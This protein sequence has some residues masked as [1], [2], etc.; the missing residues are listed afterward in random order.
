[1][2]T[3][4]ELVKNLLDTSKQ[5]P[6]LGMGTMLGEADKVGTAAEARTFNL[7]LK[8]TC[9][10]ADRPDGLMI[11][12]HV[13]RGCCYSI[14]MSHGRQ[15]VVD[16]ARKNWYI[17]HRPDFSD[18]MAGAIHYYAPSDFRIHDFGDFYSPEYI[19]AWCRVVSLC[20]SVK[21]LAFTRAWRILELV[22]PLSDLAAEPNMNLLTSHDRGCPEPATI[23][24]TEEVWLADSDGDLPPRPVRVVFRASREAKKVPMKKAGGSL[25]C[26]RENGCGLID[27]RCHECRHCFIKEH[28]V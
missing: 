9:C 6:S 13:C 26:P 14:Q 25:V 19:A 15:N 8:R 10:D 17:A 1:V 3:I 7:P 18:L 21:F 2:K 27:V 11:A 12:T 16:R 28:K 4:A 22:E 23:P 24:H 5:Y 20:P